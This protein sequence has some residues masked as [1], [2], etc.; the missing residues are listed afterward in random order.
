MFELRNLRAELAAVVANVNH[1]MQRADTDDEAQRHY[2]LL[3]VSLWEVTARTIQ[4]RIDD[5]VHVST[6]MPTV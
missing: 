2:A 3:E 5:H 4:E 1:C 6:Y